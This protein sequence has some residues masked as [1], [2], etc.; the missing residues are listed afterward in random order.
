MLST[1]EEMT[2]N[3]IDVSRESKHSEELTFKNTTT[4]TWEVH[5]K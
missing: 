2:A 3:T 5:V 4:E 1:F